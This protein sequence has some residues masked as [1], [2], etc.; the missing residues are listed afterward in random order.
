MVKESPLNTSFSRTFQ[1]NFHEASTS[2][3]NLKGRVLVIAEK[4]KA[5]GKIARA[6]SEDCITH[7]YSEV[8]YYE[9]RKG[10]LRIFVASAAGHLY[11]LHTKTPGYPVFEYTWVPAYVVNSEKKYTKPYLD[12]L[13]KLFKTC[14]Y[15]VNAC[16]YDIEGS[17]IGYLLIKFHGDEKRAFRAKFS[18]LTTP[19]IRASFTK[20]TP[21]DHNMIEA[22]LCRHELDWI[23]GINISR[24]LM[25]AVYVST[26]KKVTLSAGRVQTPTL[27]YVVDYD[28]NRRFFIPLPQYTLTVT[29]KKGAETLTAEFTNNPITREIEAREIKKT[30]EQHRH[31]LVKSYSA[32]R[33][34]YDPPPPF[35]LSDLQEEAARIYGLSPMKTQQIAEQLYLDALI[36]YPRTNSQKYP[37][38]LNYEEILGKLA[39][40]PEYSRLVSRLFSETR[41]SLKPVEGE[42]EDPAHPAIYP[43]GVLPQR[44]TRE[45]AAI[46]DLIVRRF[47]ATFAPPAVVLHVKAVFTTP[48]G[49]HAFEAKG[50]S[51]E[52][53]GWMHYYPFHKPSTKTMPPLKPGDRLEVV[54]V[55]LRETYTRPPQ[56]LKKIDILRWMEKVGIGTESTRAVIIEKLLER[57]YLKSTRTG[58]EASDLGIG[59][60]EV[61]ERFFPDLLSVDLTRK[62]E[63]L[64]EDIMRGLKRK[65]S[66]IE[67]ARK[68]ILDLLAKFDLH[69][70]DVGS[71]L[72]RRLSLLDNYE[73]CAIPG[74]RGEKFKDNVCKIHYKAY[75]MLVQ[76]Y[77]EWKHRKDISF[78]EYVTKLLRLKS[79]GSYVKE[80]I[81]YYALG[82][83]TS[84]VSKH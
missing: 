21:L 78:E 70:S 24:A 44:L 14:Y 66:V 36:S 3:W 12:L 25:R 47:L 45:Q 84:L 28:V 69:V 67:E 29:L 32:S 10:D 74:C 62:F 23:W 9:I 33:L 39:R 26:Q 60:V 6:L 58:V 51:V 55:N 42:K 15:Y 59:V 1:E 57:G 50:L 49:L 8:V 68:V 2:I 83:N 73:K 17:V 37:P 77:N 61:V 65:E 38:S 80:V 31:L 13:D 56:K 48:D 41:G 20:L 27:K 81:K 79:T 18:S 4:P 64:M 75:E 5:A 71:L 76:K 46:Y 11:E 54:K 72:A 7:R 43:T 52:Y 63:V 30:V 16:D 22:G 82:K 19:E 35:N 40:I 34:R 53:P